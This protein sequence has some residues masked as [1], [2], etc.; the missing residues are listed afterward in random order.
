MHQYND[1]QKPGEGGPAAI[2]AAQGR[3]RS[4]QSAPRCKGPLNFRKGARGAQRSQNY[5]PCSLLRRIHTPGATRSCT[6]SVGPA[7]Q[8]QLNHPPNRSPPS[9][10]RIGRPSRHPRRRC[11]T[12]ESAV[13]SAVCATNCLCLPSMCPPRCHESRFPE[14]RKASTFP[15]AGGGS[16]R[17]RAAPGD[18]HKHH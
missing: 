10:M 17:A 7:R 4:L 13:W 14:H 6:R 15:G 5:S 16:L 18:R 12:P 9:R 1:I 8:R 3:A 11:A 2:C